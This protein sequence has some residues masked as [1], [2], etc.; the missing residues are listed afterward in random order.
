[1]CNARC[2][3]KGITIWQRQIQ[4]LNGMWTPTPFCE[5]ASV[6]KSLDMVN[7]DILPVKVKNS[8]FCFKITEKF[9]RSRRC[10]DLITFKLNVRECSREANSDCKV[11]CG[12]VHETLKCLPNGQWSHVPKCKTVPLKICPEPK[13][14]KILDCSR[15]EG[16]KCKVIITEYNLK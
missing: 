14:G 7:C 9:T 3:Q 5:G 13:A 15:K 4:C 12:E 2:N 10:Q 16:E 1:M 11:S 8:T 6:V